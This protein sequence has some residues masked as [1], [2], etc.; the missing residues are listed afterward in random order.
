MSLRRWWQVVDL[1]VRVHMM[2]GPCDFL[3]M[4]NLGE[5][6]R[7]RVWGSLNWGKCRVNIK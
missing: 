5:T 3:M 2:D 7:I 4:N 6:G 1:T